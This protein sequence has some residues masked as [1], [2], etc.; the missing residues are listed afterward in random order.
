MLIEFLLD[1][2]PTTMEEIKKKAKRNYEGFISNYQKWKDL[3]IYAGKNEEFYEEHTSKKLLN[4]LYP[5]LGILIVFMT[6][7]NSYYSYTYLN[8]TIILLSIVSFI[9]ILSSTKKTKKGSDHYNKWMGLKKFL[10]DFSNMD[11]RKLPEVTLWEKYLV[12][13]LPLGCAKQLAKDMEIRIQ[14]IDPNT[15]P[16]DYMF[17]TVYLGRMIVL[18]DVIN[19]SVISSVNAAYAEKS[20]QEMSEI[21][22][23]SSSSG[24]GFGGGFSSGGGS[25]GGGGGGGRF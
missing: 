24:G 20:R 7:F 10:K 25:F 12:Y 4:V 21:S 5:L 1:N 2:K 22:S 18:N 15:I 9:Y 6:K 17:D 11:K 13:A 8:I 3:T 19:Q 16:S 23:S 14:E